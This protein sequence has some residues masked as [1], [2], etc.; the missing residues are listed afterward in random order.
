MVVTGLVA[1]VLA[2]VFVLAV[3]GFLFEWHRELERDIVSLATT[4]RN[5]RSDH[6]VAHEQVAEAHD[7]SHRALH[8]YVDRQVEALT[9]AKHADDLSTEER[10]Q[11][12]TVWDER[13]CNW[14]GHIHM[15]VCPRV[16]TH[17]TERKGAVTTERVEFWP[18]S[19]WAPPADALSVR[20]VFGA[21]TPTN[22]G[23]PSAP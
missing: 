23:E 21:P 15:G 10:N 4:I 7:E 2:L 12:R 11:L 16:R 3:G 6:Q 9:T 8:E 18:N 14:C 20:D 17:T 5:A 22:Q 1:A 13:V 19:E